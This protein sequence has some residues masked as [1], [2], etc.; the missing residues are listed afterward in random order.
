[1]IERGVDGLITD[2]PALA[3]RVRDE[4]RALAP[5]SRLLLRIRPGTWED[6]RTERP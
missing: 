1:M 3:V 2:D 4:M 5:V 6:E